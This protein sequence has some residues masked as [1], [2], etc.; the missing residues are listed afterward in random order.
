MGDAAAQNMAMK[1]YDAK[2]GSPL[3]G[4]GK[5][6]YEFEYDMIRR[7]I[8]PK[9]VSTCSV[10]G[11]LGWP[12]LSHD[13]D[14][15]A[16]LANFYLGYYAHAL[17]AYQRQHKVT[18][19]DVAERFFEGFAFR[20][21]VMAWQLSVM[22]DRFE[23]FTPRL[24]TVYQFD[25]KWQFLLWSLERQERRLGVL[26]RRFFEKVELVEL[27]GDEGH[28]GS[29]TDDDNEIEIIDEDIRYNP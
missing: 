10:R 16:A 25:R 29:K 26:R 15:L 2:T 18:M 4:V 7:K 24:P 27:G 21:H 9:S 17:K 6:I 11:A 23:G 28:D 5:E 12:S 22:R 1:K 14:N 3:Y 19:A 13:D 8:V 20:T